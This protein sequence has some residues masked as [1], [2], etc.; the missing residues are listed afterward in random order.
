MKGD[1]SPLEGNPFPRVLI[2]EVA[3]IV[4]FL[5]L[6]YYIFGFEYR[7]GENGNSMISFPGII[8]LDS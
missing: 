8:N 5:T 4:L 1:R 7:L 6:T 2:L 3:L